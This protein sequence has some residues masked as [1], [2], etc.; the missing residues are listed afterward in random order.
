[1]NLF[2]LRQEMRKILQT[3]QMTLFSWKRG[4]PSWRRQYQP[5]CYRMLLYPPDWRTRWIFLYWGT[6][7]RKSRGRFTPV[8]PKRNPEHNWV[9][10]CSTRRHYTCMETCQNRQ[11]KCRKY[12]SGRRRRVGTPS[13]IEIAAWDMP[14]SKTDPQFPIQDMHVNETSNKVKNEIESHLFLA[15]KQ[16]TYV[17]CL[18]DTYYSSC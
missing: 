3:W 2:V 15:T 7:W 12:S 14:W 8:R 1:V 5:S 17:P 16:S 11:G 4:L 10:P 9:W 13:Y 6:G 18:V